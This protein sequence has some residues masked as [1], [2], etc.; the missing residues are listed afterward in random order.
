MSIIAGLPLHPLV[1]HAAVV[2]LPLSALGV[3]AIALVPSWR[4]RYAN[5]VLLGSLAAVA[6]MPLAAETGEQLKEIVGS[7]PL[8][9]KHAELGE[10]GLIIAVLNLLGAIGIW[11]IT[12][13]KQ[14]GN[15]VKRNL[16]T[17]ITVIAVILSVGATVQVIRIGHS[18]AESA[19][20]DVSSS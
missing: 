16:A 5:L 2:L 17:L 13:R 9:V 10:T 20:G 4:S 7:E 1:V 3:I 12:R 15:P 18:G 11:W 8:V 14:I 6:V 19:W